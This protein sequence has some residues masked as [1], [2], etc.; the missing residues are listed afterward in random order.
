[1]A[2]KNNDLINQETQKF[3]QKL[4]TALQ[5]ED[6]KGAAEAMQEMQNAIAQMIEDEFEQYKGVGDMEILENRGLE[7]VQ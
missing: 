6:A 5:K 1:M 2:M 7:K 3:A 4:T